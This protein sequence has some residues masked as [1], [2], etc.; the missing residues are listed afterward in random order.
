MNRRE[1]LGSLPVGASAFFAGCLEDS[2]PN[3]TSSEPESTANQSDD[4][5]SDRDPDSSEN[6]SESDGSAER[7]SGDCGP[8]DASLPELLT[9]DPGDGVACFDGAT[10]GLVV[11]ND[12]EEVITARVLVRPDSDS[13]ADD[14]DSD[15]AGDFEE[16][17]DLEP[18]VVAR[19]TVVLG[20]GGPL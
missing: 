2:N 16:T 20:V 8:G 13:D 17:Y 18:H 10:P 6:S 5:D 15:S 9:T 12:R 3:G 14:T 11:E 1:L 19:I 4:S 7:P